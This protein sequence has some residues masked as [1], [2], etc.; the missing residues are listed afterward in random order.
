MR[1]M[2]MSLDNGRATE[3]EVGG[4][5]ACDHA[6]DPGS[7]GQFAVRVKRLIGDAWIE[8][9]AGSPSLSVVFVEHGS[10]RVAPHGVD[11]PLSAAAL[12]LSEEDVHLRGP[13]LRGWI[14]RRAH[15]HACADPRHTTSATPAALA[16][17]VYPVGGLQRA[18]CS[19]FFEALDDE[20]GRGRGGDESAVDAL[21]QLILLSCSRAAGSAPGRRGE[22]TPSSERLA[23]HVLDVIDRRFA[24]HLSLADVAAELS[25]SPATVA[26]AVRMTTGRSVL[27][28]ITERRV[29]E[30]CALLAE[31]ELPMGEIA[32]RVGYPT[33]A[34]FHRVFRRVHGI[35]PQRWR[36]SA[37]SHAT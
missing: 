37:R 29:R 22:P 3:G 11:R 6:A 36:A 35:T 16:P 32:T 28:L 34:Y 14:L 27:E 8:L 19:T 1:Q 18:R 30:A 21:V 25:R 15:Q 17:G 10:G 33:L 24:E 5:L 12:C 23:W 31:S 9:D 26:R 2:R 4:G 7:M 13:G 20:L